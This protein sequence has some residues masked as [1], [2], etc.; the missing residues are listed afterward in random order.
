MK[1]LPL[2]A[3]ALL[4]GAVPALAAVNVTSPAANSTVGTTF[5]VNASAS[6]CS[7]QPISS[8]G[9]SLDNS[10]NTAIVKGASLSAK[11]T[12]PA[13]SHVLHVKSWGTKGASCV[14]DVKIN[15]T[16]VAPP[17]ATNPPA[18]TNVAVTAPA[19]G[20][21]LT[22]PFALTAAGSQCKSQKI[23]AM[24][25]SLD[26]SS[27]TTI[28]DAQSINA[29]VSAGTGNHVVHVKSWGNQGSS[30]VTDVPVS[31][32]APPPATPP[33]TT[34]PPSAPPADNDQPATSGPSIPST[35][36]V[37]KDLHKLST[38][39]AEYD[40]DTGSNAAT[41]TGSTNLVTSPS[42]SGVAR[43]FNTTYSNYGGERY[44]VSIGPDQ[45][46]TNFVY[47]TQIYIASPSNSIANI[48]MDLNQVTSNGQTV[49]MGFQCDGWSNTWDYT[50]NAGTPTKFDD[51]WLHSNQPC[52]PQKWS[53]NTWH[54]VQIQFSRDNSGNVTYHS[55]WLDGVQQDLNVTV[56]SSFALGW[57]STVL[58]NFQVD[59]MTSAKSSSTVY[60]DNTTVYSW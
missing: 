17:V 16:N 2:W 33:S 42:A 41:A 1:S 50:T 4:S 40:V 19:S 20:S 26:N 25:Y 55:V 29:K 36:K 43:Q 22:S 45:T 8:M 49:I 57:A 12:A 10:S 23:A 46:S 47:E 58:I 28:V 60:L 13:G 52:N 31:I 51:R 56:P 27:S 5:A 34:P 38:W 9:Y 18:A 54:K 35:A 59:S 11:V 37:L 15:V 24:G 6:A 30:C 21:S 14:A 53:T 32:I 48:E 3:F 39:K 44:H 7:S